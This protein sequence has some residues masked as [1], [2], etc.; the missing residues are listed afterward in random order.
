[1]RTIAIINQK[2]GCGK[3][4]TAIN[5]AGVLARFGERT[6]L[7]D[8]DPQSHC[9]A[10][11]AIPESRIE[12]HIGDA[13][14][15]KDAQTIDDT[16]LL[17]RV[18]KN[19]DLAPS[20]MKLAGL[21][22]LRGKLADE[23]EPDR[24]LRRALDRW[25]SRYSYCLIDCPPSIGLLTYNALSAADEVLIPVETGF[26]ALQGAG[27]QI[28]TIRSLARRLG[29]DTP[30]RLLVTMHDE[31]SS[32]SQELLAELKRRFGDRL[33]PTLIRLDSK[34]KDAT[35][36]GQ[37]II[38]YAPVSIGAQDYSDLAAW[39]LG[40]PIPVFDDTPAPEEITRPYRPGA[41]HTHSISEP[42]PLAQLIESQRQQQPAQPAPRPAPAAP[43][44]D[45]LMSRAAELAMRA[46]QLLQRGAELQAKLRRDPDVSSAMKR[47]NSETGGGEIEQ[48]P[49]PPRREPRAAPGRGNITIRTLKGPLETSIGV[50]FQHCAGPR[51]SVAVAGDFNRWSPT[52]TPMQY[53]P[54]SG[55]H[56]ICVPLPPGRCEYRLVVDGV[57]IADP[58]NS[59]VSVN[60]Y[61]E[62][63]SVVVVTQ[64]SAELIT[65][66]G[67]D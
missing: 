48:K 39:I 28:N 42:K 6:L 9:A 30:Y 40:R 32:L 67:A 13:M 45:P 4:T 36:M 34:L 27:R 10:G 5:L 62:T 18:R 17:W 12:L 29:G 21:E 7:V 20:L 50:L 16:R 33:A 19:F 41:V 14:L 59:S 2:G 3:T 65:I 37:P 31:N 24:G 60:P 56:E 58:A 15:A 11:L 53:N 61:G 23:E 35:S 52:E 63:N 26:F 44:K 1:M 64:R 43:D 54:V 49:S 57:W 8:L 47:L 25:S 22:A 51:T 55:T 38:E 66:E 46:R